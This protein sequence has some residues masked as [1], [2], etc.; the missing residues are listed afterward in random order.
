MSSSLLITNF[1]QQSELSGEGNESLY[2]SIRNFPGRLFSK[3]YDWTEG[4]FLGEFGVQQNVVGSARSDPGF[5]MTSNTT[6]EWNLKQSMTVVFVTDFNVITGAL[7]PPPIKQFFK[8]AKKIAYIYFYMDEV[9]EE[10]M[11]NHLKNN[12]KTAYISTDNVELKQKSIEYQPLPVIRG[13]R[14]FKGFIR[15]WK[16]IFN[17]IPNVIIDISSK[18]YQRACNNFILSVLHFSDKRC[19]IRGPDQTKINRPKFVCQRF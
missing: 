8:M 10:E 19:R 15:R 2:N 9:S 18:L 13:S 11:K 7:T 3:I 17:S 5:E 1:K 6:I 4:I 14:I 16:Y 12:I